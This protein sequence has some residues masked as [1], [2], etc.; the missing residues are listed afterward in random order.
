MELPKLFDGTL[1]IQD[2]GCV[3]VASFSG[4]LLDR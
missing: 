1:S 3:D 4:V 2:L